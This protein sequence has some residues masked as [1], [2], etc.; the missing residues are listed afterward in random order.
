MSFGKG[1]S[2]TRALLEP[3]AFFGECLGE[4][5]V[6]VAGEADRVKIPSC[7]KSKSSD[8]RRLGRRLRVM[9]APVRTFLSKFA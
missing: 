4:A 5:S 9:F 7:S 2:R 3:R 1:G 6:L 8:A